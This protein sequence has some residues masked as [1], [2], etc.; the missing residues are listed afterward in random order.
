MVHSCRD[1]AAIPVAAVGTAGSVTCHLRF[2]IE[3]RT[4]DRLSCAIV[5]NPSTAEVGS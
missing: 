3:A 1:Q 2:V 5:A 4:K